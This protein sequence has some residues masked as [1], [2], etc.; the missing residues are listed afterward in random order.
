MVPREKEGTECHIY[1][2]KIIINHDED[3]AMKKAKN[4]K[5][6]FWDIFSS[7]LPPDD[8]LEVL[9][10][11][12][13][14]NLMIFAGSFFLILLG[15]IECILQDYLLCAVNFTFFILI[16]WCFVFLR[17]TKNHHLVSLIGTT[18]T[19]CFYTFFIAYG[20]IGN[21]TYVWSFTYPLISIFLLGARRGTFF[22][23]ILLFAACGIF[24]FGPM[25][26]FTASYSPY[27]IIRFVPAYLTIYLLALIMEKTREVFRNRLEKAKAQTENTVRELEKANNALRESDKQ[28]RQVFESIRDVY[29]LTSLDGKIL[30]ISPSIREVGGYDPQEMVGRSVLDLYKNPA[31]RDNLIREMMT[32]GGITNYEVVCK[33]QDGRE[34]ISSISGRIIYNDKGHPEGFAGVMRDITE[35]K[36]Y[37]EALKASEERYRLLAD[38]MTDNLWTFDLQT[39]RYSYLSPSV[40]GII[41]F[42][43]EEAIEFSLEEIMTPSSYE[44]VSNVLAEELLEA[45]R[46]YDPSRSRTLEVELYHKNG[47]TVWTEAS[48][49]FV[50]DSEKQ[51]LALL[52]VTRDI[53]KRKRLQEQLQKSQKMESLGL[54]A[55][56]VAHDLNNVLSGIVSYPELMLMSLPEVSKLRKPLET[57]RES[58][59]RAA[60]IVQDL[61]TIARGVATTSEPLNLNEVITDYMGSPEF[62]VL[63]E[64][65][66]EVTVETLLDD[67]LLNINA[68]PV[69]IRKALMNL[70]ANAA[71]SIR[72]SGRVAVATLNRYLDRPLKGYDEISTG[73]YAVLS[74][75]DDGSGIAP[76]DLEKI[77]EPFYTRK[78]MGRSG[79]GL[80]LSVVWNVMRDH[81]GYIDVTTGENGTTFELY[82]PITRDPMSEKNIPL[83]AKDYTGSGETI[84]V[85]DDV[86]SQREIS[87]RILDMLNYNSQA[88]ASGEEAV[89]FLKNHR[90]DLVL[91]DMIMDPGI[92]GHETYR[93]ILEIHPGQ[94]AIILSGYS[95]S[96]DVKKAQ[97][98]GAGQYV[99]KPVTLEKIGLAI[100]AALKQ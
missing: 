2:D 93:R 40:Y 35:L 61:L 63:K 83:S 34:V 92:N 38:N 76:N 94:K 62:H 69:H 48:V 17:K 53:S 100:K 57:M 33:A 14:L 54:L 59:L 43:P 88:V 47:S 19:G 24:I 90:A 55:G 11:V 46:H 28:Y 84:L 37:V 56:G 45:S 68:S 5:Q 96:E 86:E 12:F 97:S 13:L 80:G 42:T 18:T 51:P 31:D 8:D 26:D 58:G 20:G 4:I 36:N 91:L 1:L 77:F 71:E 81:K 98:L 16:S 9:R 70:V 89:E 74:V 41:G 27:L 23:L 73:E 15:T 32:A 21:T 65:Y 82:F 7:G 44:V 29:Y 22:S 60:A 39:M 52:G 25:L 72:G 78:K 6:W 95:E 75:S 99:K 50:Y 79:T 64:H 10:K 87:C 49:R 3:H 67:A 30:S 85:V 66:P